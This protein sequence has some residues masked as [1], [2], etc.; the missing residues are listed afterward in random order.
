MV[1]KPRTFP[2]IPNLDLVTPMFQKKPGVMI[3]CQNH[4]PVAEGAHRIDGYE[5]IDGQ[6]KASA[7]TY[8]FLNFDAGV[9]TITTGQTVTGA[10]SGATG[11]ALQAATVTSG[12]YGGSNAVGYLILGNVTG[13][14]Q[15]NENLQVTAVTKSVA[16]GLAVLEGA[17]NDTDDMTFKALAIETQR[18]LIAKI[19]GEGSVLGAWNLAGVTY[20]FRNAVGGATA[21]MYK[22][23]TAGWSL[24]ALGFELPYTSGGT[25]VPAVGDVITGAISGA[26]ATL[27][28]ITMS[29]SQDWTTGNAAGSMYFLT[30]TGNFQAENL[31]IAANL[32]VATI[33]ANATA[34]TLAPGGRYDFFLHNFFA[35]SSSNRLYGVNGV[36]PCF[37]FDGTTF[38]FMRSP[39]SPDTPDH[40]AEQEQHLILSFPGGRI[41]NSGDGLPDT[42]DAAFGGGDY[43]LGDDCTGM[44]GPYAQSLFVC[45]RNHIKTLVGHDI[46]DFQ[47]LSNSAFSGVIEWT[48][49]MATKPMYVDDA[50]LRDATASQTFG[51][52]NIGTLTRLIQPYLDGKKALGVTAVASLVCKRKSQYR[53]FFS[54]NSYIS[55]YFGA[56]STNPVTGLTSLP[57]ILPGDLT[58]TPTCAYSCEDGS[59]NEVM[60]IGSSSGYLYQLDSGTNFDGAE[61]EAYFRTVYDH[62]GSPEFIKDFSRMALEGNFASNTDIVYS[63]EYSYA[64]PGTPPSQEETIAIAGG[65]GFWSQGYNWNQF[66]WSAGAVAKARARLYGRGE[67]V[68]IA[69]NSNLTYEQPYTVTGMAYHYN[70]RRVSRMVA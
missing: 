51:N 1:A 13:I 4:E 16:N 70:V 55:V 21:A 40:L 30:K 65:G 27:T 3:A 33:A 28:R 35:L 69:I 61:I 63:A 6:T 68:S 43:G 47:L 39:I 46:N 19:P 10:T 8:Y 9:G 23:T 37:E 32:N 24:V 62:C 14:F 67:N 2:I 20:G 22:T 60:L 12:T 26:T 5:R 25:Y 44:V 59:G 11:K 66:N 18:A 31:N 38:A 52:F 48:L 50:G 56:M 57:Y 64:D 36:G 41:I 34:V 15:D 7:A 42:F 53:L 54:D 45:A 49:Q 58:I 17:D 29:A